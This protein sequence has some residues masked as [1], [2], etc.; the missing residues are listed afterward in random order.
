V[1]SSETMMSQGGDD[2]MNPNPG[3]PHPG[4]EL[5]SMLSGQYGFELLIQV[6]H[7]NPGIANNILE[8]LR[9][10]ADRQVSE[11]STVVQ[12]KI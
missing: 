10:S 1:F 8:Q 7:R 6:L 4:A 2:P 9:G 11:Q 12:V 3:P 5:T